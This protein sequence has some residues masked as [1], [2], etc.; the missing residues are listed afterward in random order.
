MRTSF[1]FGY[2]SCAFF[3]WILGIPI[4]E[5][6]AHFRL[7]RLEWVLLELKYRLS[8]QPIIALLPFSLFKLCSNKSKNVLYFLGIDQYP[9]DARTHQIDYLQKKSASSIFV[10]NLLYFF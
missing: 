3:F 6:N 2:S 10:L 4:L 1:A 9:D 5:M 8:D 7:F